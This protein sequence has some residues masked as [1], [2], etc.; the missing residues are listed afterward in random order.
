[1][2]KHTSDRNRQEGSNLL[3]GVL[4]QA[5]QGLRDLQN[6]Q[7]RI[8]I[9]GGGVFVVG[10][11]REHTRLDAI[12]AELSELASR[13]GA[14]FRALF[15]RG[16]SHH[17]RPQ[18][19][20][21]STL[22]YGQMMTDERA[23]VDKKTSDLRQLKST[24]VNYIAQLDLRIAQNKPYNFFGAFLK[25]V[26]RYSDEKLRAR[27]TFTAAEKKPQAERLLRAVEYAIDGTIRRSA[28]I[29]LNVYGTPEGALSRAILNS[30]RLGGLTARL[31]VY[32]GSTAYDEMRRQKG[33]AHK[34]LAALEAFNIETALAELEAS[35]PKLEQMT[36]PSQIGF[37][38][39]MIRN[40]QKGNPNEIH[41]RLLT[42]RHTIFE[43]DK[44]YKKLAEKIKLSNKEAQE[45]DEDIKAMNAKV[46]SLK[47][48]ITSAYALLERGTTA[49]DTIDRLISDPTQSATTPA[50]GNHPVTPLAAASAGHTFFDTILRTCHLKTTGAPTEEYAAT[51]ETDPSLNVTV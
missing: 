30:G 7:T 29:P 16:S 46:Q 48:Q 12:R 41:E 24:L 8:E 43:A 36:K 51:P 4:N 10:R 25:N 19:Q 40:K 13:A 17:S 35:V 6:G 11:G 37:V 42:I 3:A 5:E 33:D 1:M 44:K 23:A 9:N 32:N 39:L 20:P 22:N 14:G 47:A 50:Q 21:Q 28:D 27:G 49:K 26:L 15:N 18:P 2:P 34:H 31:D 45:N 38:P